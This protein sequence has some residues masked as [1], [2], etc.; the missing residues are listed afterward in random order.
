M[1]MRQGRIGAVILVISAAHGETET[2]ARGHHDAGRP[3]LDVELDRLS[4]GE[5]PF[6]VVAVPGPIRQAARRI[7]LALRGPQPSEGDGVRGSLVPMKTTSLPCGSNTRSTRKM[8]AS[9]VDDE[10]ILLLESQ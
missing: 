8:S 5:R 10:T 4:R 3:D 7:E 6:L 2:I 9:L 1:R